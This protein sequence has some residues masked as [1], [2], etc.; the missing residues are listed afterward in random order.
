MGV[1]DGGTE[2]VSVRRKSTGE[3]DYYPDNARAFVDELREDPDVTGVQ[4]CWVHY[5]TGDV[6]DSLSFGDYWGYEDEECE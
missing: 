3:E 6:I 5:V 1:F 4:A 2:R